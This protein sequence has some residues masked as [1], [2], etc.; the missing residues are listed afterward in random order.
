MS[1]RPGWSRCGGDLVALRCVCVC[2]RARVFLYMNA[3]YIEGV[4][5]GVVSEWVAT[6]MAAY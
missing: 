5:Y 1:R 3:I 4:V 2:A 6:D